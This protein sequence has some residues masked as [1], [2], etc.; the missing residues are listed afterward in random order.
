MPQASTLSW[1]QWFM[2]G[3]AGLQVSPGL[4]FPAENEIVEFHTEQLQPAVL[5]LLHDESHVAPHQGPRVH[6]VSLWQVMLVTFHEDDHG[7]AGCPLLRPA[8]F[9]FPP[10]PYGEQL[11]LRCETENPGRGAGDWV[12]VV[13]K[14]IFFV[15]MLR[16][17][18][19]SLPRSCT[20]R[21][22]HL[23]STPD[24]PALPVAD[25]EDGDDAAD[26]DV[27]E[28]EN[29]G[30]LGAGF[31]APYRHFLCRAHA[32]SLHLTGHVFHECRE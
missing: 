3:R 2:A 21:L 14:F 7:A 27:P 22:L 10:R 29:G 15:R 24:D 26:Y 25:D 17:S 4:R 1:H 23:L 19:C 12:R 20:L 31:E 5:A 8:A 16:T 6:W 32:Q 11:A 9:F 28:D 13:G 18:M 30:L